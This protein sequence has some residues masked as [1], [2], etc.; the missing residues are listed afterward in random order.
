MTLW[1]MG[2]FGILS[3]AG[4]LRSQKRS[5]ANGSIKKRHLAGTTLG[6]GVPGGDAGGNFLLVAASF[7]RLP[8]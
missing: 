5:N 3:K 1:G 8:R 6:K 7:N 4:Y 2:P